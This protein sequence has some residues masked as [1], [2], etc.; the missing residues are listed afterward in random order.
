MASFAGFSAAYGAESIS[1]NFASNEAAIG[2][3][4]NA[5]LYGVQ[6]QYWNQFNGNNGTNQALSVYNGTSLSSSSS[7]VTWTSNNTWRDDNGTSTGDGQ[8]LHGYLDDGNG[9]GVSIT[10]T[11]LDF[12][13]YDVY[14]YCNTDSGNKK[15]TAK[16]VNGVSYSYVD[17][18]VVSNSS[19]AWGNSNQAGDS[20]ATLGINTLKVSDQSAAT[21]QF[22]CGGS[23]AGDRGC[24][25]GIQIVDTYTGTKYT[26]SLSADTTTATW[27][28]EALGASSWSDSSTSA[29]TYASISVGADTTLTI[30][31]ERTTDA[32]FLH[33][34]NM[35]VTGGTLNLI[36]A[37]RLNTSS[38][39]TL[40]FNT[41]TTLTGNVVLTGSGT[42]VME[43]LS[44]INQMTVDNGVTLNVTANTASTYDK[45]LVIK[46]GSTFTYGDNWNFTGELTISSASYAAG[47]Y[48][49]LI[50]N[51]SGLNVQIES[52]T[53]ATITDV[54]VPVTV[55]KTGSGT[56][57]LG[58]NLTSISALDIQGGTLQ[59]NSGKYT[60]ITDVKIGSGA[61]LNLS[62]AGSDV[63]D[64]SGNL[65]ITMDATSALHFQ[66]GNGGG[67][68]HANVT[69]N[70][71]DSYVAIG[72]SWYGNNSNL[73]GTITGSGLL[74]LTNSSNGSNEMTISATISDGAEGPLSVQVERTG[75][76]TLSG[77]NTYTGGTEVSRGTLKLND[78]G[79]TSI[80]LGDLT[81]KGGAYLTTNGDSF[82]YKNASQTN[83]F[84]LLKLES[85]AT[86]YVEGSNM[87][88]SGVTMEFDNATVNVKT[89]NRFD[90]FSGEN[91]IRTLSS[92]AGATT[93]SASGD[94]T[95]TLRG[96]EDA[97]EA[98][99]ARAIFDIAARTNKTDQYEADLKLNLV[100][101][102]M[103]QGA[104]VAFEKTGSGVLEMTKTNT[105]QSATL[106]KDGAIMLSESATL[107][108]GTG[109]VTLGNT[110]AE[111]PTQGKLIL[112]QNVATTIA[113]AISGAGSVEMI[114]SA[115]VT[116]SGDNAYT[117]GTSITAGT[118]VASHANA[119]GTGEVSIAAGAILE[120][121]TTMTLSQVVNM[122]VDSDSAAS[123]TVAGG[124]LTLDSLAVHLNYDYLN[125][126]QMFALTTEA[127]PFLTLNLFD[128]QTGTQLNLSDV[129]LYDMN[130]IA[131]TYDNWVLDNGMLSFYQQVPEPSTASLSL[132]GLSALLLRRRRRN[133]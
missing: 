14:I 70:A 100:V 132:L 106:I 19:A 128:T 8:L 130:G 113:N 120:T 90:F 83:K 67:T 11:N 7:T 23:N 27:T 89:S 69:V 50:A 108:N 121:T 72:G 41:T 57:Q 21:L 26:S 17:G 39:S 58:N 73:A 42:V 97:T 5:G 117:G 61:T 85:G 91:I 94:Q 47:T 48:S 63:G 29:G 116:L 31:G 93:L 56:A 36:G 62:S 54:T 87:T 16:T 111:S 107:G 88:L 114:G 104:N 119:L 24:V 76:I 53:L 105:Y 98:A 52:G 81:V 75:T 127:Q 66:N 109:A 125:T 122:Q 101:S 96:G 74:M 13:S 12:L 49:G 55:I 110:D 10:V 18:S 99:G 78:G 22:Y 86:W 123:I 103:G 2:N 77:H 45:E 79:Q 80:L 95:L 40:T 33:G 84:N 65:K 43:N 133:G 126:P 59:L 15:F 46:D 118:L 6:G 92:A 60:S 1:I 20:A 112:N 28:N 25:A 37:G 44:S 51:A 129:S 124:S 71:K 4:N 3:E 34:G 82:G 38:G 30:Q 9:A 32:L 68:T 131:I 64:D 115:K 102:N 35:T